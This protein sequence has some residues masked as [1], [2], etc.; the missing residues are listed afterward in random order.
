[1]R[2][3]FIATTA[4]LCSLFWLPSHAAEEATTVTGQAFI[5][6][7]NVNHTVNSQASDSGSLLPSPTSTINGTGADVKRFYI[8]V[9]HTFDD[10]WSANVTTDFNTNYNFCSTTSPCSTPKPETQIYIKKAYVQ[11]KINDALT[12][13][14]GSA[15]TSWVPLSEDVYSYL[16]I[17]KVLTDRNG[18]GTSADWGIHASGKFIN[19]MLNYD[20][21]ILNGGGYKNPTRS[22]SVDYEGRVSIVPAKGLTFATGFYSG[23]LGYDT[24]PTPALNSATRLDGLVSYVHSRFRIGAEYFSAKNWSKTAITTNNTD[25]ADGYSVWAG[26]YPTSTIGL[27]A[28]YEDV[29]PSKYQNPSKKEQYSNIGLTYKPRKN[30]DLALVYKQD[31][32]TTTS[33]ADKTNEVGIWSKIAY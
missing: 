12:I 14:I 31:K 24:E 19:G 20:A 32:A 28:R 25:K 7:S 10:I 9:N 23:K 8:G 27:I 5:D 22:K 16:Y 4:T 1:M 26:Y 2:N 21:G 6:F 30:I 33:S 3:T 29:N 18:F 15:D 11:A 13:K 17:E